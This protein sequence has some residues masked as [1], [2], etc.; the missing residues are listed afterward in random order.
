MRPGRD[1]WI[2]V[3]TFKTGETLR[4]VWHRNGGLR[5]ASREEAALWDRIASEKILP[6][7]P[8]WYFDALARSERSGA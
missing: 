6:R 7:C 1:F 3:V 2:D 8:R 4:R 5:R